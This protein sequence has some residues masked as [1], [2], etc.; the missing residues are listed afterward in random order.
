MGK[1][2]ARRLME[3]VK[4]RK[5]QQWKRNLINKIIPVPSNSKQ[6]GGTGNETSSRKISE[7]NVTSVNSLTCLIQEKDVRYLFETYFVPRF[8]VPEETNGLAVISDIFEI[9]PGAEWND[10]FSCASG[11][12]MC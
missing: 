7:A 12:R 1:P 5:T 10:V 4:K 2:A 8:L 3:A 9:F 6:N 11:M